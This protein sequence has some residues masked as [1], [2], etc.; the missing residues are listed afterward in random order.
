MFKPGPKNLITDVQGISVGNATSREIASGVTVL[1][2]DTACVASV[3]IRGGAP[4]TRETDVLGAEN[5]VG[6]ANAIVLSGGSV[7]GLAAGDGVT[8]YLSQQR[9]GLRL[10]DK[11]PHIPIVP[12]A[13]LHDLGNDGDKNWGDSHP[14]Y[15]LGIEAAKAAGASFDLGR[16]GAGFGAKAGSQ[17]GGLGSASVTASDAI[18]VG[19]LVAANPVGSVY[20]GDG[21]TFYAHP[22]ERDDEFGGQPST[23]QRDSTAPFPPY[24]R[25]AGPGQNTT[26][27]IVATDAI[28]TNVEAKR[29]AIMAQDGI[30]RAVRPAHTPF[31]GDIVFAMATGKH[32][33]EG[34]ENMRAFMVAQLGSLAADCVARSIAR[35]VFEAAK[36]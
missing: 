7:F 28:L 3:D 24:S 13:V 29:I 14:Y 19:A 33:I 15:T 22:L 2:S 12:A 20:Y 34:N 18:A 8:H 36:D 32:A 17:Q 6:K 31:D 4:G 25:F 30:A 16:T 5:L 1:R 35:A 11:G 27:C 9:I 10:A 26:L 23:P 21:K